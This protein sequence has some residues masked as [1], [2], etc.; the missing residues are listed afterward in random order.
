MPSQITY[1]DSS[2]HH[3]HSHFQNI[4]ILYKYL[5][6]HTDSHK[7]YSM[8]GE[9]SLCFIV[10]IIIFKFLFIDGAMSRRVEVRGQLVG[11][12]SLFPPG[13]ELRCLGGKSIY[14]LSHLAIGILY[15]ALVDTKLSL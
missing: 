14:R 15:V 5:F 6:K 13:V 9:L 10:T 11:I 3:A 7:I 8:E 2:D 12:P 1:P 4:R